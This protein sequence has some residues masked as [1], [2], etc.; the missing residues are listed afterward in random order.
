MHPDENGLKVIQM[1][2]SQLSYTAVKLAGRDN[3]KDTT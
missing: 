3:K 1:A 2:T